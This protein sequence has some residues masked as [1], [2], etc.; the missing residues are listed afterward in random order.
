MSSISGIACAAA[1]VTA[2][3]AV[4]GAWLARGTTAVPAA[5]WACSAAIAFAIEAAA[6]ADGAGDPAALE[7]WRLVVAAL[8]LCPIMALLGAKRPQHGVWQFIVAALGGILALPAAS[9]A[10]VRPGSPPDVH[11]LQRWFMLAVVLVAGANFVATRHS[12]AALLV[13]T[14]QTL[15]LRTLLP[16]G[17]NGVRQGAALDA[18]GA[19]IV[20]FGAA[21]AAVQSGLLPVRP[22]TAGSGRG[23]G[24]STD[25]TAEIGGFLALRETLGAAWTLRIAERFNA[26]ASARGW[27]CRL[28]FDGLHVEGDSADGG[29]QA[30]AGRTARALLRRFVSPAW[31]RRHGCAA[32]IHG[33]SRATMVNH[34]PG[35]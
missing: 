16:F 2:C 18:L 8:S 19:S 6:A 21:V 23:P 35:G 9:A 24:G 17:G 30:D 14:G 32:G 12:F 10:L 33:P 13:V 31:L 29:W 22:K 1:A 34:P 27:P 15:L 25:F 28:R 11:P 3:A 7:S 26:E 20:A 4:A 5:W